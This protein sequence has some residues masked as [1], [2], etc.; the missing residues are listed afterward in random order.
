M[1]LNETMPSSVQAAGGIY[2]LKDKITTPDVLTAHF[3]FKTCPVFW[4]H[5]LWGAEEYMPQVSNGIFFYGEKATIFAGDRR[6]ELIPKGKNSQRTVNEVKTDMGKEH[7]AQFLEC[8]K[9]RQQPL[10]TPKEAYYST[11]SV[12]L[13]MIAYQAGEKLYWDAD[14]QQIVGNQMANR[15]LKREYRMPWT[16]PYSG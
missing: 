13:A 5:R 4:R 10:C 2:Y 6:W 1:I 8:V 12:Q 16:H 14:S 9:T 15:L 7:M 11:S 3:D